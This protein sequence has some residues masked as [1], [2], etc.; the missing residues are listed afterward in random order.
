V[1]FTNKTVQRDYESEL[2][3]YWIRW[4]ITLTWREGI[5]VKRAKGLLAEWLTARKREGKTISYYRVAETGEDGKKHLHVL[6]SG[7]GYEVF[8]LQSWWLKRAG[9]CQIERF[10]PE[11]GGLSYVLKSLRCDGEH[12]IDLELQDCHRIENLGKKRPRP[13]TGRRPKK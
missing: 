9:I 11:E 5:G 8:E 6:L 13:G 3:Q 4:F 12:D 7:L 10:R 1:T 2:S